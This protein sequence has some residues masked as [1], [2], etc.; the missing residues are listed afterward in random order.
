VVVNGRACA[1][2]VIADTTMTGERI[3]VTIAL[4]VDDLPCS[5]TTRAGSTEIV[6][7]YEYNVPLEI[8]APL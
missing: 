8:A 3:E 1:A 7:V 2:Y 5:I 6:T 4:G